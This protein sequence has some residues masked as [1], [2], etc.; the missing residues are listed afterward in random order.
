[1][2]WFADDVV[3]PTVQLIED[4]E[5]DNVFWTPD[6]LG[7]MTIETFKETAD[8]LGS[9]T[10]YSKEQLIVLRDKVV[11]VRRKTLGLDQLIYLMMMMMLPF[12]RHF[13]P[14]WPTV[15]FRWMPFSR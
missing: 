1:M 15:N 12:S 3:I 9:T 11:E 5:E 8:T 13:Y 4:L 6:Q 2:L 14:K 7:K 10:D